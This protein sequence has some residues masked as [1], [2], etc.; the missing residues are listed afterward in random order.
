[1]HITY[2]HTHSL[3]DIAA[4]GNYDII[5][6]ASADGG[7]AFGSYD[8]FGGT[9]AAGPH[10]AAATALILQDDPSRSP[11]QVAQAITDGA[12]T[13]SYMGTLPDEEWGY[14][15]MQIADSLLAADSTP[16]TTEVLSAHNPL[17]PN[18]N[19]LLVMPSETLI[20]APTIAVSMEDG[21]EEQ[22][23]LWNI[24]F[25]WWLAFSNGSVTSS[26]VTSA[27]DLA[28]NPAE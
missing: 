1:M 16:P 19:M 8:I 6:A 9:S 11:E 26:T 25:S 7:H 22:P 13:D 23:A 28:G 18:T 5:T 24:G 10:V 3:L 15:K 4:P 20:E 12:A 2:M 27:T 17:L 14:G 21:S